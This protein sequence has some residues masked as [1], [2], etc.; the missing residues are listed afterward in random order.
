MAPA[1]VLKQIVILVIF[2]RKS[3]GSKSITIVTPEAIW[4]PCLVLVVTLW[5]QPGAKF[6]FVVLET[7]VG[8]TFGEV[9]EV[10]GQQQ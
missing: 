2:Y 4:E 9:G 10:G 6:I 5:L 3:Q 7:S 1:G 8:V